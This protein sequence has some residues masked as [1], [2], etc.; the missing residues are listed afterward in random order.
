MIPDS[1][2]PGI[3]IRA[4]NKTSVRESGDEARRTDHGTVSETATSTYYFYN[5]NS[6]KLQNILP[7]LVKFTLTN[8]ISFKG[9]QSRCCARRTPRNPS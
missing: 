1:L 4:P 6:I 5:I 8:T 9:A 7:R 3:V 2:A